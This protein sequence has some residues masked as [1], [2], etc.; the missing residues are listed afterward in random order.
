MAEQRFTNREITLMFDEIKDHLE[1]NDVKSEQ[2]LAQVK[3][4]NGKVKKLHLYLSIVGT[5]VVTLFL[6]DAQSLI[7]FITSIL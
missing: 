7:H 3:F 2:I 1:R 6:Q 5:S 4:T